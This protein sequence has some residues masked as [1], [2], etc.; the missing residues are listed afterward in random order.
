MKKFK[1]KKT[2]NIVMSENKQAIDLL[3]KSSNYVAVE[4]TKEKAAEKKK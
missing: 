1:N 4:E 2:G 3:E